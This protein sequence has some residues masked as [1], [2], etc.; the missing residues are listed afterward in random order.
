MFVAM[1]ITSCILGLFGSSALMLIGFMLIGAFGSDKENAIRKGAVSIAGWQRRRVWQIGACLLGTFLGFSFS[2]YGVSWLS[3]LTARNEKV[4]RQARYEACLERN[5]SEVCEIH[6]VVMPTAK[7]DSDD[8]TLVI[9]PDG[10]FG[11]GL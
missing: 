8:P 9:M 7:T 5:S 4:K 1:V 11:F 3:Q 10:K 6:W 2:L